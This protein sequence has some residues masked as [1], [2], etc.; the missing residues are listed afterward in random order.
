MGKRPELV[1]GGL[2]RSQ[3]LSGEVGEM[4]AHDDRVLGS[5][6]FVESLSQEADLC[7]RLPPGMSLD[8]LQKEIAA[9]YNLPTRNLAIRGR[10]NEGSEARSLFCY[11]AVQQLGYPGAAVAANLGVGSSSVSRATRRGEALMASRPSLW[12]WWRGQLKQ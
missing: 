5:G 4:M 8:A 11:L 2:R 6:D 7:Q 1:G 9:L 12:D 3:A 10:Q